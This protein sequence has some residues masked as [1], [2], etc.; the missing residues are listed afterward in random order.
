[1]NKPD[2]Y[3][4]E[5]QKSSMNSHDTYLDLSK[6][7]YVSEID[8]EIKKLQQDIDIR[9]R[10]RQKLGINEDNEAILITEE[11]IKLLNAEKKKKEPNERF[12]RWFTYIVLF[13]IFCLPFILAFPVLLIVPII[14]IVFIIIRKAIRRKKHSIS[15]LP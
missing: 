10:A 12:V 4:D 8:E 1:M 2:E 9:R 3:T 7:Q 6:Y 13:M 11:K 5:S 15:R 14:V